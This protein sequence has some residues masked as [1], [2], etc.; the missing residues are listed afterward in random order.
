MKHAAR[1]YVNIHTFGSARKNIGSAKNTNYKHAMV[2]KKS[3]TIDQSAIACIPSL[4]SRARS[5]RI[6]A[7]TTSKPRSCTSLE[8]QT[9]TTW[10]SSSR[11]RRIGSALRTQIAKVYRDSFENPACRHARKSQLTTRE[12]STCIKVY[13]DRTIY[14][15]A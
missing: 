14:D 4:R 12:N 7:I 11:V 3:E 13:I 2:F 5:L 15:C 10:I 8:S 9:A 1:V 6:G